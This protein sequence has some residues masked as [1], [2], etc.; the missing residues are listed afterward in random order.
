MVPTIPETT[1]GK[2]IV[3]FYGKILPYPPNPYT[4]TRD[5]VMEME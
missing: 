1:T 5:M 4:S 3:R 2:E